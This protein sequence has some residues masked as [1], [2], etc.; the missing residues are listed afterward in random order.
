MKTTVTF[1]LFIT[2]VVSFTPLALGQA[3]ETTPNGTLISNQGGNAAM[4]ASAILEMRSTNKGMLPPRMS[5]AQINGIASPTKG[6][7]AYDTDLNCLKAYDGTKW[8]CVGAAVVA[9]TPLSSSYAYQ[10]ITDNETFSRAISADNSENTISVGFFRGAVTF[11]KSVNSMTL[12][13]LGSADG[14]IAKHDKDGNLIWATQIGGS[15]NDQDI[16]DV[17]VDNAGNIVVSGY[18]KGATTFYS[19]NGS[20]SSF[21]TSNTYYAQIFVAKY[22]SSGVLEWFRTAS[23]SG[24]Y[25]CKGYGAAFDNA[26]NI[27]FTGYYRGTVSFSGQTFNSISNTDDIFVAKLN[28]SGTY[29]WIKT[30]GGASNTEGG[31]KLVCDNSNN[32]YLF[33]NYTSTA[34]FGENT[35]VITHTARG[36]YDGFL[37]KYD[38]NGGLVWVKTLGSIYEDY[39]G[40]I[41]YSS[42]ANAIYISGS[43]K[44]TMTFGPGLGTNPL[45]SVSAVT[46]AFN[47]FLA[48]YDLNGNIQ[49]SVR[50]GNANNDHNYATGVSTDNLGNPY[51]TGN[52]QYDSYFY[53]YNSATNYY[54]RGVEYGEPY[55]AKYN[56]SGALQWV[57]VATDGYSDSCNGL[58]VKNNTAYSIGSFKQTI[59]FGYQQLTST[60]NG[61]NGN[62]FI[63][64][65]T[66]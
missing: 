53:S 65:Y 19:T 39:Q 5:T 6:L 50:N 18:L 20:S 40:D 15:V 25:D 56:T 29:I 26:G 17:D 21:T 43:Y 35:S 3:A 61:Y 37:A 38:A 14:F 4:P 2:L 49:W 63:W 51:I 11:G 60:N 27:V 55:I 13:S 33:G 30:A 57:I 46:Y 7:M 16:F 34:N 47:G 10:S 45:A 12:T 66:E 8:D 59:N 54:V 48:K 28:T 9:S 36:E 22:N 64:R 24:N 41:T 44:G 62:L 1:L 58:V 32:V 23:S 52:L 42:A 31:S